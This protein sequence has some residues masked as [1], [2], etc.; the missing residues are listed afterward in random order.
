MASPIFKDFQ[1]FLSR[2]NVIDLA[3]GIIIG[4]AFG[5]GFIIGPIGH[6]DCNQNYSLANTS[7]DEC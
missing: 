6:R 7:R 5:I 3:V 4:A 1:D 2:G